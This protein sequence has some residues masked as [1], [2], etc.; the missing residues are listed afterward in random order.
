M[1]I[2][3]FRCLWLSFATLLVTLHATAGD[4]KTP[5]APPEKHA[6]TA[7]MPTPDVSSPVTDAVK[8][9]LRYKFQPGQTVRWE[10]VHRKRVRAIYAGWTQTTDSSTR[11]TKCWRVIEVDAQGN[12][13]FENLVENAVF[14]N[15]IETVDVK[16]KTRRDEARYDSQK[17]AKPPKVFEDAARRVGKPLT[18]VKIDARGR[19]LQRT[20]L[21]PEPASTEN[22]ELT[23][24]LPEDPVAVGDT[25]R[26]RHKMLLPLEN[27]ATKTILIEQVFKLVDVKTGVATIEVV[28]QVLTPIHSPEIEAKLIERFTNGAVRFDIEAG[29]ILGL[30]MDL[31][32]RVVG[33]RGPDSCL[34]Y[35]TRSTETLL[36]DKV[37]VAQQPAK[38]QSK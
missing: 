25:W 37:A 18:R 9:G 5:A 24:P 14:Q 11:S 34:Q 17:D 15:S 29:R 8:Y 6:T 33:F 1:T 27:K 12:A 38:T 31:D 22:P 21:L 7:Q 36:A 4:P 13:V 19:T 20:A 26:R 10:V 16:Q 23:I 3:L 2:P 32:R 28:N 35:L 30:Q